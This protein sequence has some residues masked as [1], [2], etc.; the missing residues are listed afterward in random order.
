MARSLSHKAACEKIRKGV[1]D[2][3][4]R[5]TQINPVK[6][7]GSKY[8]IVVGTNPEDMWSD[9]MVEGEDYLKTWEAAHNV[10]WSDF[11]NFEHDNY[12]WPD[13]TEAGK[14]GTTLTAARRALYDQGEQRVGPQPAGMSDPFTI[15]SRFC[16]SSIPVSYH[17]SLTALTSPRGE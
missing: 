10:L 7:S 11:G 15:H 1:A 13:G 5:R 3:V 12:R 2:G 17:P 6:L 8:R 4:R 16:S 14:D 9:K